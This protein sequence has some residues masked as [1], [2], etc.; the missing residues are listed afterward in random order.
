MTPVIQPNLCLAQ[1]WCNTVLSKMSFFNDVLRYGLSILLDS[2]SVKSFKIMLDKCVDLSIHRKYK[3]KQH[4]VLTLP[5]FQL[6]RLRA[7]K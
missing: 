3:F 6:G 4:Y 1:A 5:L 2:V 7:I